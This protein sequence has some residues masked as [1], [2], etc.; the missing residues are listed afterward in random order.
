MNIRLTPEAELD[1]IEIE[2]Y[3][4]KLSPY[5]AQHFFEE[6]M[7][8][9]DLISGSPNAGIKIRKGFRRF[10]MSKFPYSIIYEFDQDGVIVVHIVH[11]K[12]HPKTKLKRI[13]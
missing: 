5:L 10:Q 9:L 7:D 2:A 4:L 12:R 8:H 1:V 11:D 3:Y 13:K 6:L